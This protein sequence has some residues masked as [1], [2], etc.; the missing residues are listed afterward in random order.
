M[1]FFKKLT[2]VLASALCEAMAST[3]F[4]TQFTATM[5]YKLECEFGSGPTKPI[6]LQSTHLS[7]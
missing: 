1:F 6:S 2:T 4:D 5:I 3:H 7:Q